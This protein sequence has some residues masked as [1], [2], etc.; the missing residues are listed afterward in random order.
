MIKGQATKFVRGEDGSLTWTRNDEIDPGHSDRQPISVTPINCSCI[1]NGRR[2][3]I[4]NEEER[5]GRW[6]AA[7]RDQ[8][9]AR[10]R[11]LRRGQ[12]RTV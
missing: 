3:S 9:E 5:I 6:L 12:G 8:D 4:L 10:E 2:E 11:G 1:A 7:V